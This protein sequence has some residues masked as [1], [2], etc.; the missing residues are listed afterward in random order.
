MQVI[1]LNVDTT[2]E[3]AIEFNQWEEPTDNKNS[4]K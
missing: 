2:V 4:S 1:H 3:I